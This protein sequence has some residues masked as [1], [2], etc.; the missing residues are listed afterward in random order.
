MCMKLIFGSLMWIPVVKWKKLKR[1]TEFF[2]YEANVI[3]CDFILGPESEARL[4]Y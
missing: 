4:N 2:S 3:D 1:K